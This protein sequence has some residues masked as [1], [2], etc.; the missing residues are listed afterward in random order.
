M[1]L[2]SAWV[3]SQNRELEMGGYIV[4][5]NPSLINLALLFSFLFVTSACSTTLT[6]K[7]KSV[8]VTTANLAG[9]CKFLGNVDQRGAFFLQSTPLNMAKNESGELGANWIQRTHPTLDE[10]LGDAYL[11]PD[12]MRLE[13]VPNVRVKV[14]N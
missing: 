4:G 12:D 11:C 2:I 6:A 9:G 10:F 8:R 7:G 13:L 5:K 1:G 14:S 3:A